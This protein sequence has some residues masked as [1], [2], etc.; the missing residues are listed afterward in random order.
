MSPGEPEGE[1]ADL[2][3]RLE[4]TVAARGEAHLPL[5]ELRVLCPAGLTLAEEFHCVAEIASR[6]N[7]T[8][9]FLPNRIV[10]FA[11]METRE[12]NGPA[13]A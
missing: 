4:T 1:P 9:T 13:A 6:R 12:D 5:A 2:L 3:R 10:R 7:W 8:F 11:P